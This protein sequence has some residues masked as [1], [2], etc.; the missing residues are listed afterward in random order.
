MRLML[1]PGPEGCHRPPTRLRARRSRLWPCSSACS[2]FRRRRARRPSPARCS[3]TSPTRAARPVPGATVTATE[4]QH[5]H[6]PHRRHERDRL[7]HFSSLKNG[8]YR[9][10]AEL[11]GFK[12]VVRAGVRSTSTRPIRVDLKLEVGQLTEAVTVVGRDARSCRPTA[13]TP[14]RIIE[15]KMVTEMPLTFNRNFQSLLITVPGATRPHREHSA[16]LQLAGLA[17]RSRST[18]SRAWRTTRSSRGSTTTTRPAC[19]R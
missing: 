1:V 16:V 19:C 3:A 15:S 11:Q 18:A 12:K 2:R 4:T 6:Q 10:D 14:G 5:Q 9:V 17:W 8:T 7:L 13:P